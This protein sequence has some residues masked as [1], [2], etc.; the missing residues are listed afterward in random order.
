[1]GMVRAGGGLGHLKHSSPALTGKVTSTLHLSSSTYPLHPKVKRSRYKAGDR[2]TLS[3][4]APNLPAR[5]F[6]GP[7]DPGLTRRC[8]S[9]AERPPRC[10]APSDAARSRLR[11]APGLEAGCARAHARARLGPVPRAPAPP[12]PAA[13]LHLLIHPADRK[14]STSR[15]IKHPSEVIRVQANPMPQ[16]S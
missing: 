7:L 16:R 15:I 4:P 8:R 9:A 3:P 1:M 2:V 11:A 5:P 14:Q 10:A 13:N 12:L 6:S